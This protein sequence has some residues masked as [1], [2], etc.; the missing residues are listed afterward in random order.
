MSALQSEDTAA[1]NGNKAKVSTWQ[2]TGHF[3]NLSRHLTI[4]Q[5]GRFY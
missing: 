4:F 2:F 1:N 5:K 3:L